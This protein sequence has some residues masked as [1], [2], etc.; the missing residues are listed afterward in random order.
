MWYI[1]IQINFNF[2]CIFL[3]KSSHCHFLNSVYAEPLRLSCACFSLLLRLNI[4]WINRAHTHTHSLLDRMTAFGSGSSSCFLMVRKKYFLQLLNSF[5]VVIYSSF[6]LKNSFINYL[7]FK[8][9]KYSIIQFIQHAFYGHG[10]CTAKSI[11]QS[12]SK[13]NS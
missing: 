4:F 2:I 3:V 9:S 5:F 12:N 6:F 10:S 1:I 13:V 8:S 7:K 11:V